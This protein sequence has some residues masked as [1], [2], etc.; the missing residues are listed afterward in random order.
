MGPCMG[1]P[2]SDKHVIVYNSYSS[3]SIIFCTEVRGR[4]SIFLAVYNR[5]LVWKSQERYRI[6]NAFSFQHIILV[7]IIIK[8]A[9]ADTFYC[10]AT[11]ARKYVCAREGNNNC[12]PECD[13]LNTYS[14]VGESPIRERVTSMTA[15]HHRRHNHPSIVLS[16]QMRRV[17]S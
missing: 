2:F 13:W 8:T 11:S 9:K 5:L 17:F 16:K 12:V 14:G 15:N 3:K 6:N 1:H 4:G 7:L 10:A